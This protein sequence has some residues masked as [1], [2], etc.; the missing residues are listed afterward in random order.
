[1]RPVIL[2]KYH[3]RNFVNFMEL[4]SHTNLPTFLIIIILNIAVFLIFY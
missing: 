2:N 3:F 1:M 4:H